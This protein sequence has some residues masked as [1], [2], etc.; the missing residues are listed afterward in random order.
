M[1]QGPSIRVLAFIAA[2]SASTAAIVPLANSA[3]GDLDRI[4]ADGVT[5]VGGSAEYARMLPRT[6]ADGRLDASL[7]PPVAD[8]ASAPISNL[9]YMAGNAAVQGNG[10]PQYPFKTLTYALS[11]MLPQSAL[12][13]APATYS[14]TLSLPSGNTV[15]IVGLG[16]S[17]YISGLSVAVS[18]SSS[19][20]CLAFV[21]MRVGT[22]SITGGKVNVKLSH[23]TVAQLEGNASAATIT[24][25]DLGSLVGFST[26]THTDVYAGYD[27][28]PNANT[29]ETA[30]RTTRLTLSGSRALVTAGGGTHTIAY[31][32]D[33]AGSTN[34][35]HAALHELQD[36]DV[37][38]SAGIAAETA[39]RLAAD[40]VLSN[41]I[42]AA[43]AALEL[44]IVDIGTTWGEQLETLSLAMTDFQN[45]LQ[46]LRNDTA[47]DIH[48]LTQAVEA[49]RSAYIA[50]DI[51]LNA[52]I[53]SLSGTVEALDNSLD[54][55]IAGAAESAAT[56]AI[57]DAKAGIVSNA[58]S[59]ANARTSNVR[60]ELL[61]KI[62]EKNQELDTELTALVMG[63]AER[64]AAAENKINQLL[65]A[66]R[67]AHDSIGR[68][69]TTVYNFTVPTS[70]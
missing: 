3:H 6:G 8:W 2:V 36:A 17:S 33:V 61:N 49:V 9:Y 5:E 20:T 53:E 7:L 11:H 38:L 41:R 39:G 48:G 19:S 57:R 15:A 65:S 29:L 69:L 63:Y 18:G 44:Q 4:A 54:R 31:L 42:A 40:V 35:I 64:I 26:L 68:S 34:S 32:S 28:V 45:G 16:P 67:G 62:T 24:R 12:L 23:S 37:A 43:K 55:R 59:T 1:Y 10:S 47:N 13:V 46:N 56:A 50:A 52:A 58:V 60:T 27:T 51:L 30:D 21:G 25:L 66:L 14:G 70:L 22:L